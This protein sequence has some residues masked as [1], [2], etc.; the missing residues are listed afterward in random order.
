VPCDRRI[1]RYLWRQKPLTKPLNHKTEQED[2]KAVQRQKLLTK[3]L[4]H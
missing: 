2:P 1:T 4:N 3:P